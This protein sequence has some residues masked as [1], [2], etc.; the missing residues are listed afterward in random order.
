MIRYFI[1]GLCFG[2]GFFLALL[3][4]NFV[5]SLALWLII[6]GKYNGLLG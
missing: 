1:R 3:V 5:F 2:A 4:L 6:L